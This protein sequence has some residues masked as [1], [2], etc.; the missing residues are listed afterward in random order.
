MGVV[1]GV[2]RV[3]LTRFG[4]TF[5]PVVVSHYGSTNQSRSTHSSVG[6]LHVTFSVLW[7][8]VMYV[9]LL[10]EMALFGQLNII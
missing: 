8:E 1:R 10:F 2:V 4:R 9:V 3:S 7:L 5:H 6:L